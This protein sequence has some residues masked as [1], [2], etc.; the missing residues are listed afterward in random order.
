MTE[1]KTLVRVP[2]GDVWLTCQCTWVYV[3]MMHGCQ[4]HDSEPEYYDMD[5]FEILEATHDYGHEI[6]LS[7]LHLDLEYIK[8]KALDILLEGAH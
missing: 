5:N 8:D 6:P 4:P 2:Y 7:K 1:A 3:P